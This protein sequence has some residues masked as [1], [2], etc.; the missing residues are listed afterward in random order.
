MVVESGVL[1][2]CDGRTQ[3]DLNLLGRAV[4][5]SFRALDNVRLTVISTITSYLTVLVFLVGLVATVLTMQNIVGIAATW[6]D[7]D[8]G[9]G[10]RLDLFADLRGHLGYGGLAQ[11]W[12]AW[13]A[14]DPAARQRV[15]HDIE[16]LR[17][18]PP[19]WLGARPGAEEQ[20]ALAEVMRRVEGYE[21]ALAAGTDAAGDDTAAER[22]LERIAA[23]LRHE[24]ATGAAGVEDAMWRLGA[25]VSGVMAFSAVLLVGLTVFFFWFTRIRVVAPVRAAAAAMLALAG[26]DTAVAVPFTDKTDEMGDIA[27]TVEIFKRNAI[28]RNRLQQEH[29]Q[30]GHRIAAQRRQEMLRIASALEERLHGVVAAVRKEANAIHGFADALTANARHTEQQSAVVAASTRD[31][32]DSVVS[33]SSA[34]AELTQSVHEISRQVAQAAEV[35]H[36]AAAEAQSAHATILELNAAA[37]RIG[38]IVQLIDAIAGQTNMLALNATIESA[39]VGES[40]KGF[41]VVANEVKAL[42]RQT[43]GATEQIR[44]QVGGMQERAL[45]T[46]RTM[47]SI[48]E[49]IRRVDEMSTIIAGAVE[50][51]GAATAAIAGNLETA[52]ASTR[53]VTGS[54]SGVAE[55]AVGTG[56]MAR[57]V[58]G[59]ATS[60]VQE[61]TMLEETVRG[62][63][64]EIR[65]G[66][67]GQQEADH[68]EAA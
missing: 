55:D 33:A 43:G 56:R 54:I 57:E 29:A 20:Q 32:S 34:G 40:G 42:A 68:A 41:A 10:R 58:F 52:S 31:A 14:G 50:Q 64:A 3:D 24:R 59:V 47:E 44:T 37:Q 67:A 35:A 19:A 60:L 36:Q 66:A 62:F 16:E 7:F 23:I 48:A 22:A 4:R 61:I 46:V 2:G 18:I 28:E 26:G 49:T 30:A 5:R 65:A 21:R 15:A 17:A 51:Q 45:E 38:D 39:R 25:T 27:R 13:R 1:P 9:L 8:T 53:L 63:L 12:A 6:R 11:H